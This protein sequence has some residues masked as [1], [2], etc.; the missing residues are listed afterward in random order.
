MEKYEPRNYLENYHAM[1]IY[2]CLCGKPYFLGK[3]A[4]LVFSIERN[5]T[6]KEYEKLVE[7]VQKKF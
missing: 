5:E 2:D 3:L 1:A 7:C 4:N 6:Q